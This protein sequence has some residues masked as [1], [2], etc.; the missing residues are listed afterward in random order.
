M[1]TDIV[2]RHE[3]KTEF[4]DYDASDD[5]VVDWECVRGFP[6]N[7]GLLLVLSLCGEIMNREDQRRAG[8]VQI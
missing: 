6:A 2:A 7:P 5:D 1:I 3:Q 4:I 8:Y